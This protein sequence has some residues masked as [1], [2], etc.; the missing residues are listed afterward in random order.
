MSFW[1]CDGTDN[2]P[3]KAEDWQ[4]GKE[5]FEKAQALAARSSGKKGERKKREKKPKFIKVLWKMWFAS[6]DTF[7]VIK[8][9]NRAQFNQEKNRWRIA[10]HL[11][12]N[13][14]RKE[15]GYNVQSSPVKVMCEETGECWNK[16]EA[17]NSLP[18]PTSDPI[19]RYKGPVCKRTGGGDGKWRMRAKQTRVTFSHG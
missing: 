15:E 2:P 10:K 14:L 3:I 12:L 13:F 1:I 19:V 18:A 17:L 6:G 9:V 11:L 5:V 7:E 16:K 4:V 8:E